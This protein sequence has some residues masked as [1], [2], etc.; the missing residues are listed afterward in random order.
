MKGILLAITALLISTQLQAKELA[1]IYGNSDGYAYKKTANGETMNPKAL[2]AA[3]RR[4][5][6]GTIVE[7]TNL[8]NGCK[9][10]VRINDRGPYVEGRIIDVTPAAA[11]DLCFDGLAPVELRVVGLPQ[12]KNLHLK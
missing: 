1:S 9:T 8:K 11:R 6:F 7:V 2:T 10:R 3:H 5:P 4:L 12:Q